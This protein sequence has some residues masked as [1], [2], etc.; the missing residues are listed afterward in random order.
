VV[1]ARVLGAERLPTCR[2]PYVWSDIYGKRLQLAG[3]RELADHPD[4]LEATL[5]VGSLAEGSF[6]AVYRRGGEPVA[7]LA[8]DQSRHFNQIRRRL[9]TP[10][11]T[12]AQGATA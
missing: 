6:A 4:T 1:A 11:P 3:Y 8:L 7:V 10:A 9:V 5:E 2:P 12:A